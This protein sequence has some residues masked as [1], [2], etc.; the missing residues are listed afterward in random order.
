MELTFLG[1][2]VTLDAGEFG[3]G[4]GLGL[5]GESWSESKGYRRLI[6]IRVCMWKFKMTEPINQ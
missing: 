5:F 2:G 6:D 3:G 1:T 4:A